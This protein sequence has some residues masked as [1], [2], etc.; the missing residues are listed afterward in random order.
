MVALS[1]TS[2]I[3]ISLLSLGLV[4]PRLLK[5]MPHVML[6]ENV[7]GKPEGKLDRSNVTAITGVLQLTKTV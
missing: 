4:I 5:S 6:A 3:L 7:V 2:Y 1:G